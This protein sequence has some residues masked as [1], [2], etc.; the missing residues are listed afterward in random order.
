MSTG[1]KISKKSPW[2]TDP[3][4]QGSLFTF[5]LARAAAQHAT[6][7]P[8]RPDGGAPVC[9]RAGR[10]AGGGESEARR[11]LAMG[12]SPW[13]QAAG[14]GVGARP[15]RSAGAAVVAAATAA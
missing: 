13:P 8:A 3:R 4:P 9:G 6:E 11:V 14:G 12:D 10:F 5:P 7:H 1:G 15:A 2:C